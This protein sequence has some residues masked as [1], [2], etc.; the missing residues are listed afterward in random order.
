[1]FIKDLGSSKV[2]PKFLMVVILFLSSWMPVEGLA[3]NS[4]VS[5]QM[6]IKD[7]Q[8]N[9]IEASS[10]NVRV[11]ILSESVSG[12][13]CVLRDEVFNGVNITK[14]Y[15]GLNVGTGTL[16]A[17]DP[18]QDF[19][20][21]FLNSTPFS[22][23][24]C[25]D[26]HG[27]VSGSVTAY[28]PGANDA[29][30]FKISFSHSGETV[31][32]E[33][34]DR[35]TTSAI[36]A[37]NA[38]NAE[39]FG[40]KSLTSF[41][42]I[43]AGHPN[44]QSR[45]DSLV[46]DA[47]HAILSQVLGG[48]YAIPSSRVTGLGPLATMTVTGTASSSTYL[49]GDG[50]WATVSGGGGGGGSVTSVSGTSP[51]NVSNG[52][53][54]PS[55]SI[56]DA[57]T[58]AK[59]VVQ[60]GAGLAVSS[61]V[62]SL[63]D[64][65]TAGTY[66]SATEVPVITTDAKGRVTGVTNISISLNAS[67]L[68]AGTLDAARIPSL[69][70]SKITTGTFSDSL[71][72][73]LNWSK[74]N[75]G[76]PTT[77]GGYGITDAVKN[78][79]VDNATVIPALSAG[80][81]ASKPA[82]P[83]V[84]EIFMATDAQ[85]IYR[86][87]GST[88]DLIASTGSSGTISQVTAGS[89]L[90]GGGTTGNVTLSVDTGTTADKIV[91]LD[92]S[93]RLPAVDASL[94]T[95]LPTTAINALTGDVTASGTGSVTGSV[96]AIRGNAVSSGSLT[97][98]D[99]GKVYRWNGT[100]FQSSFLNFGD[101]RTPAG[102]QQLVAA[103]AANEK[104]QWSTI[105]DTFTCQTIGSLNA[106]AITAGTMDAARLPAAT[107]NADGIVN[108]VAQSFSGVKTFIN[109]LVVQGTLSVTG[110]LTASG[111]IGTTSVTASGNISS[112]GTVSASSFSSTGTVSTSGAVEADRIKL[113]NSN[114]TCNASIEGSL[115][116]NTSSKQMEVCNGTSW[117]GMA[118]G[119]PAYT[120]IGAPS[121]NLV[122]SGPVDFVISYLG[123]NSATITLASGNVTIGGTGSSGCTV[124]SVSGS[125]ATRIVTVN[126]CTGTGTVNIS[127]AANTAQSITGDAALAAGPSSTYQV[128]NTGPAAPTGVTLG[129]VPNNLSSSPTISYTSAVD[130][131][132]S[133]TS[134]HQVRII[135]TSD[136][137]QILD[138]TN[139]TS[140]NS[141]N[142]L[143]LEYS[144]QYSVFVR[145]L[146]LLGNVGS[147]SSAVVWNTPL[148]PL[149]LTYNHT[150]AVQTLVI[151]AGYTVANIIAKGA[152]GGVRDSG[153][154]GRGAQVTGVVTVTPGASYTVIVGGGGQIGTAGSGGGGGHSSFFL[155]SNLSVPI[156]SAG[157]GGGG[158]LSS[159]RGGDAC[160]GNAATGS[161]P[162][163]TASNNGAGGAGGGGVSGGNSVS[164]SGGSGG[165]GG[166]A[167]GG[168]AGSSGGGSGGYGGGGGG[169]YL[170]GYC[171]NGGGAGG[172]SGTANGGYGSETAGGSNWSGGAGCYSGHG[173]FGGG[174][175]SGTWG[176][177]GGGGY[178]GGGGGGSNG[179]A[180]GGG[181]GC[182]V[183]SGGTLTVGAGGAGGASSAGGH[184]SLTI[185]L[186]PF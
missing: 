39:K 80:L 140:G 172:S 82:S 92:S 117:Q 51:I 87:N 95:N 27:T 14:G 152:G 71:V 144:T 149:T 114:A 157:G 40:G 148:A 174:G 146:D 159:D 47:G 86:Y 77:L 73:S 18:G 112:G 48:T 168:L 59:G 74:I 124:Q 26:E 24:T 35:M 126:N 113:A 23:L 70:A 96:V 158:G 37:E 29:R 183:P 55:I 186:T 10:V 180:G 161:S 42:Q 45:V 65:G 110:L 147:T 145:A 115:R 129:A 34:K 109:N 175:G 61:G 78:T 67:S 76:K 11:M 136:S 57:S 43:P 170:N 33:F 111:G 88:W 178:G 151:P 22:G 16:G 12:V 171:S 15:L 125:G 131:G 105:T 93:A 8:G 90:T 31:L 107:S 122:K 106:S 141:V 154:G 38:K 164:V 102:A 13:S 83:V 63:P 160:G 21:V 2:C 97:G 100:S 30:K 85:K 118:G 3:S 108:Q 20:S 54:T 138:W 1:M 46:S 185:T 32:V 120:L 28:S 81:D 7:P 184:G 72:P 156:I 128:D 150:G 17:N 181:G 5:L 99:A 68:T 64:T 134:T 104:I 58:S 4:G 116:Y 143:T 153:P 166:G 155:T 182:V 91:K 165:S 177:G 163:Q 19:K 137:T 162:G 98:P 66:G 133:S 179:S 9:L 94:L 41:V 62:V 142:G 44:Y 75:S 53:T 139:H 130:S 36:V 60:L 79:G 103:C 176:G 89:G 123:V 135:R 56:S 25:L 84:G 6:R 121:L 69:D 49:R 169:G 127:V 101:L 132:G 50:T 52:T 167:G 173:G 119:T